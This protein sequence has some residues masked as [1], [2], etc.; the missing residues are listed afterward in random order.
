MQTDKLDECL[1][2]FDKAV[3][4]GPDVSGKQMFKVR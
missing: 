2:D 1:V 3:S 4:L